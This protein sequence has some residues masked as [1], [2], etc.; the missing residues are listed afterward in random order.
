LESPARPASADQ[1]SLADAAPIV[2]ADNGQEYRLIYVHTDEYTGPALLEVAD[3]AVSS[4][5]P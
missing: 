1:P 5:P 4:D 2:T 3:H